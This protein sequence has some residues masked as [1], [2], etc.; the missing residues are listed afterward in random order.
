M[1]PWVLT[2][3]RAADFGDQRLNRRFELLLDRLSDKP[4][5]SI[6]ATCSGWAETA[7]AYRFFDNPRVSAAAVLQPHHDATAQR[8]RREAV[9]LIPQDTTELD[10]TR[11]RERVGGPLN[12][13]S[14]WGLFAHPQLAL[15]PARLPL[16]VI[17]ATIWGRDAEA[18]ARPQSEKRRQRK[19]RP[20]EEKESVRWLDGYRRAC[21]VAGEAP[22]T[23]VVSISD[24]EGDIYECF[25]EGAPREGRRADW[26]VRACQDRAL[27][28]G[29]GGLRQ[30]LLGMP[31]VG[32]LS[33]RV[34]P[35]NASAGDGRR[36][37]QAR[38]G[39]AATVSVRAAAV[40]LRPPHRPG[41]KLPAV[42]VGAILVR[43]ERP[44]HGEEPIEWLLLTS[45]PVGGFAEA[46][47]VIDYYCCRWEIEVY[48][49]VLKGGCRV[50]ELQLQTTERL[51]ACLAVYLIVAW[52][53]LYVLMLGRDCPEVRCDAVLS[54]AEWKSVYRVVTNKKPPGVPPSLGEMLPLI[55]ELGGYLG[56]KHDGPPGPKAIWIGL[57]RMRDFAVAWT[58]FHTSPAESNNDV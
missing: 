53:V 50:E 17:G 8:I 28:E 33:I 37:R 12:D 51:E 47:T 9:V 42:T 43:E 34:S 15:T 57:Q 56:R 4:S 27:A 29:T 25:V 20:I 46:Q 11:R 31:A 32:T 48:F 10:L 5:L 13:R 26:I 49:R 6:P 14:R 2:E 21:R 41:V 35:R 16:G 52:R 30:R 36:R 55:A 24:S 40:T 3:A 45:L 19:A 22:R 1:Q 58:L 39:R 38:S 44:P 23:R 7:A 54:E 18:F